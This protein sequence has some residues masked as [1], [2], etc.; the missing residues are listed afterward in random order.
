MERG[1][2]H[3]ALWPSV[4]PKVLIQRRYTSYSTVGHYRHY[5]TALVVHA[6]AKPDWE[7]EPRPL[8]ASKS[9]APRTAC[10]PNDPQLVPPTFFNIL[11]PYELLDQQYPRQLD[12]VWS[13]VPAVVHTALLL[14][15]VDALCAD[16][17]QAANIRDFYV[18]V[19]YNP[20]MH[21]YLNAHQPTLINSC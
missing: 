17:A 21:A 16:A 14:L 20:G 11:D 19:V 15:T 13:T 7:S 6:T 10:S 4:V 2:L 3:V 9:T 18:N 8:D 1:A 5:R 12:G